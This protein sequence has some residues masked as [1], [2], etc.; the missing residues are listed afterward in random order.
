MAD[1]RK[2]GLFI[3]VLYILGTVSGILSVV[4]TGTMENSYEYFI[5]I[6][7][8]NNQ[9]MI[10]ALFILC[11][12]FSLAFIPIILYP[13]ISRQNKALALGYVVFSQCVRNNY[14]YGDFCVHDGIIGNRKKFI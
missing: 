14:L 3:G 9:F 1:S 12:G 5:Q 8:K 6:T 11:M 4:F 2:I 13:I 10:G 7:L